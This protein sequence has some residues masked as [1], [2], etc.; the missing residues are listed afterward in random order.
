MAIAMDLPIGAA[1][2]VARVRGIIDELPQQLIASSDQFGDYDCLWMIEIRSTCDRVLNYYDAVLLLM[3]RGLDEPAIALSRS[4]HE[5]YFRLQFLVDNEHELPSWTRWQMS[6]DFF[7]C[8]DTLH[9]DENL[10]T[11]ISPNPPKGCVG[12][13]YA[14]EEKRG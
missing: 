6:R 2:V 3:D 8:K 7:V 11:R 12:A 9:F 14:R 10:D 13:G 1:Q 4:I 5:S